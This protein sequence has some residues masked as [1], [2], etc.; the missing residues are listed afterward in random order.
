M[1]QR[2]N[3]QILK[4]RAKAKAAIVEFN[5]IVQ[6]EEQGMYSIYTFLFQSPY[7]KYLECFIQMN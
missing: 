3:G 1:A 7:I 6:R 4:E 2:L 5:K